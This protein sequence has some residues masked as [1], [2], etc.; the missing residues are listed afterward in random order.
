MIIKAPT[1]HDVTNYKHRIFLSGAIDI[2]HA[3][4][5]QQKA[6]AMLDSP[7]IVILN[8]RRDD[9]DSTWT[10]E[11]SDPQFRSQVGWELAGL[12]VSDIVLVVFTKDSKAPITF[13]ELGAFHDKAVVVV[14]PG[15]YRK[16]NI[17]IFCHLFQVPRAETLEDGIA[18]VKETLRLRNILLTS[19]V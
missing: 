1:R 6:E 10:Q 9:W 7:D 19:E 4:N 16:G 8:P 14:E 17:D 5:W 18:T 2:G 12:S 13:L 15:F 3:V 11:M